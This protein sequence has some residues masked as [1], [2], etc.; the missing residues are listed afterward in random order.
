MGIGIVFEWDE[1]KRFINL[2]KHGID[3][4]ECAT[5][6]SGPT[7]TVVDD[8]CDYGEIRFVTRGLLRGMVVVVVHTEEGGIVRV[9]SMRKA[10]VYEKEDFF[11]ITFQ[12]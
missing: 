8:R 1:R 7:D 6:F 4:L 3:F 10:N 2:R 9:I 12:N 5:V 11:E